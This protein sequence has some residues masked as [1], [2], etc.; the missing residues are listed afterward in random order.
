MTITLAQARSFVSKVAGG[1]PELIPVASLIE[2]AGNV[3]TS[4]HPWSWL[5]RPIAALDFVSG[6]DWVALP[7]DYGELVA[8]DRSNLD[9]WQWI[10]FDELLEMRYGR[11][12]IAAGY[13]GA[14]VTA[15]PTAGSTAPDTAR[16]EIFPTPAANGVGALRLAYRAKWT[17]VTAPDD[18]LKLPGYADLL[19]YEILRAVVLGV[20]EHDNAG[21]DQRIEAVRRGLVFAAAARRDTASAD[22]GGFLRNGVGQSS[23]RYDDIG[24]VSRP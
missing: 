17:A 18:A 12:S 10:G 21:V 19:F 8:I 14:I 4:M 15:L 20:E 1:D 16:I 9:G 11:Q 2:M 7:A 24:E 3:L 6:Q 5:R 23:R 22:E 13:V